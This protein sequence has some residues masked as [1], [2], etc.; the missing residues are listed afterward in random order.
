MEDDAAF[1]NLEKGV[2]AQGFDY[3]LKVDEADL[4]MKSIGHEETK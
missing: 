2:D 4:V 1:S 3:T